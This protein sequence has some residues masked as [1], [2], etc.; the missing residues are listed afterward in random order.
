MYNEHA[1]KQENIMTNEIQKKSQPKLISLLNGDSIR[2][3]LAMALP[4]ALPPD[5]FLRVV[6]TELR[7]NPKLMECNQQS[8]FSAIFQLA[9]LGLEPG[10]SLGKAYLIP[11]NNR[12]QKTV[13]CQLIIGYRGLLDLARRSGD[14]TSITAQCVYAN[15]LF[16]FEYGLNEKLRHIP[17][18]KDRGAFVGAYALAKFKDGS[19]QFEVMFE[20]KINEIKN[21]SA[22]VKMGYGPWFEHFEEMARKTALRRLCKYLPLTVETFKAIHID[23]A[24]DRG[25][26]KFDSV[27]DISE[28]DAAPS[29][30]EETKESKEFF[31][32]AD[33]KGVVESNIDEM[34]N[35]IKNNGG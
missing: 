27:I 18:G 10:G 9:Q 28:F 8:F 11:F 23:E 7:N 20:N 2:K 32:E 33:K 21:S 5:R 4:E 34:K 22:G 15:D 1:C 31:A 3:Q 17:T 19:Y 6:L 30:Q 14:I 12:K 35:S 25:Q 26:Q 16:E 24:A 13:D 29:G